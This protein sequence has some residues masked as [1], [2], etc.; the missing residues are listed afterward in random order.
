MRSTRENTLPVCSLREKIS[1]GRRRQNGESTDPE[2][3]S[4]A[5]SGGGGARK[6]CPVQ[7]AQASGVS[8]EA[9]GEESQWLCS[10]PACSTAD[11][12]VIPCTWRVPRHTSVQC[13]KN[14]RK[15]TREN[16]TCRG[17]CIDS[18][19]HRTPVST[20]REEWLSRLHCRRN[21]TQENAADSTK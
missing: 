21:T 3:V 10:D 5:V 15:K 17:R 18:S 9:G 4:V 8:W 14:A 19:Y 11:T 13:S 16:N 12:V 6:T 7:S 2:A 1:S 20:I